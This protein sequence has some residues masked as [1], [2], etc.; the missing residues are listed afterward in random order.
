MALVAN[1]TDDDIHDSIR[2]M[3]LLQSV[4]NNLTNLYCWFYFKLDV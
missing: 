4:I 2:K 1:L 3:G